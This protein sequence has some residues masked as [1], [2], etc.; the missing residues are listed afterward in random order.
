MADSS[1]DP[2]PS[3]SVDA[4]SRAASSGGSNSSG[5]GSGS[6]QS[7]LSYWR[8]VDLSSCRAEIDAFGVQVA[9]YQD[10]S[11]SARR[12]LAEQARE[13]KRLPAA[14]KTPASYASLVKAFQEEIDNL[15]R[16]AKHA[17][18]AF[19]YAYRILSEAPDPAKAL[20]SGLEARAA[21]GELARRNA[22]LSAELLE[23]QKESSEIR[24]QS[25]TVKKLK[26]QLKA[27]EEE[28]EKL[29]K[30]TKKL[31]AEKYGTPMDGG[32][33]EQFNMPPTD[34]A[35]VD[36]GEGGRSVVGVPIEQ[37]DA[38]KARLRS[39]EVEVA[40]HE[41]SADAAR[42]AHDQSTVAC[43][44]LRRRLEQANDQ[45]MA[46]GELR[47]AI[48]DEARASLSAS[49]KAALE[50]PANDNG[51]GDDAAIE[52]AAKAR[53]AAESARDAQGLAERLESLAA[54]LAA[55]KEERASLRSKLAAAQSAETDIES[56]AKR[57]VS[58]AADLASSRAAERLART[59]LGELRSTSD[60]AVAAANSEV[61]RLKNALVAAEA[62]KAA[63]QAEA[64]ARPTH[65]QWSA[66]QQQI[67]AMALVA[68]IEDATDD[69]LPSSSTTAGTEAEGV[70]G[71]TSVARRSRA[72]ALEAELVAQRVEAGKLAERVSSLT[73]ENEKQADELGQQ[74]TLIA[75]LEGEAAVTRGGEDGGDGESSSMATTLARQRNAYRDRAR[76]LEGALE[77]ASSKVSRLEG[78]QQK[79]VLLLRQRDLDLRRLLSE[80]AGREALALAG[81]HDVERGASKVGTR[82]GRFANVHDRA[83]VSLAK[84]LLSS[85][86]FRAF[87]A[88]YLTCLHSLVFL[89]L[90][91][92]G[93]RGSHHHHLSAAELAREC[94]REVG[95][96]GLLSSV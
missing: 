46:L 13:H 1:S 2:A 84:G 23:Y 87:V 52:I 76:A 40:R 5:S 48:S 35:G 38:L 72:A 34:L 4:P 25:M 93:H 58:L 18:G 24:D 85:G 62:S 80:R 28:K 43:Q 11:T 91:W 53:R 21:A 67:A 7:C 88:G 86:A 73:A 22:E 74:R 14:E 16:R 90:A 78:E 37:H 39:L 96:R 41:A 57:A 61:E 3:S 47:E 75:A 55:V 10:A 50:M 65:A 31:M 60:T 66:A 20:A 51:N 42:S 12:K 27:A 94:A 71:G 83:A 89:V 26:E 63:A 36:D 70:D 64:E 95:M 56:E 33:D 54:E 77:S 8:T 17:E 9:T 92:V 19:V 15:T 44:Q 32:I 81:E 30:R 68:G 69:Q 6:Q 49:A 45:L 79:Q 82:S 59:R 29:K